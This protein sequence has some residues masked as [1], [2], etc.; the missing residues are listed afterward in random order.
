MSDFSEP[1]PMAARDAPPN[2]CEVCGREA[3]ECP[4]P[5]GECCSCRVPIFEQDGWM[6]DSDGGHYCQKCWPGG[7]A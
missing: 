5:L 3:C 2:S 1:L 6:V 4:R 7:E